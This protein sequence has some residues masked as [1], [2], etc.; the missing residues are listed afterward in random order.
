MIKHITRLANTT[1]VP[2]LGYEFLLTRVFEHFGIELHEKVD[3]Q[4]IDEVGCN[5]LMG[6]GF[7]LIKADDSRFEQGMQTP[8]PPVPSNGL[9]IASLHR[10]Q[11]RMK[12]DLAELKE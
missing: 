1:Q 11:Q 12:A 7:K 5:T 6:C 8:A 4:V 10:K 9:F 2:D 3:T